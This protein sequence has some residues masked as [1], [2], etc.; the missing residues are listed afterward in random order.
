MELSSRA[1]S[2]M[3]TAPWVPG[4]ATL[5]LAGMTDMGAVRELGDLYTPTDSLVKQLV[6]IQEDIF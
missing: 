5:R 4:F 1:G 2:M 3:Q 6:L